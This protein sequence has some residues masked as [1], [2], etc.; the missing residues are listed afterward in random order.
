MQVFFGPNS[1]SQYHLARALSLYY[2]TEL[3]EKISNMDKGT[4]KGYTIGRGN[5]L[6]TPKVHNSSKN[7]LEEDFSLL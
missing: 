6:F 1:K 4:R 2:I 7:A 3:G 5:V